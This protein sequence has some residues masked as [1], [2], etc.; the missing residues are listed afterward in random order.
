MLPRAFCTSCGTAYA[1]PADAFCSACGVPRAGGGPSYGPDPASYAPPPAPPA[2]AYGYGAPPAGPPPYGY[3]PP[4]PPYAVPPPYRFVDPVTGRPLADWWKR[5]VAYL[6]DGLILAV[7]T[8]I[9]EITV[10]SIAIPFSVQQG[11]C[12]QSP[13]FQQ[14]TQTFNGGA[15][16]GSFL[17]L[18]AL[19]LALQGLYFVLMVGGRR[20]QTVGMMALGIAVRDAEADTS[21]GYGRA[22]VRYLVIFAL[23][24]FCF[25][26]QVI[27][28]LSPLW[29]ARRQAWHDHAAR[30]V[31]TDLR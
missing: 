6:L 4:P 23:A 20:G 10:F 3:A 25:I 7:P 9:L 30:S 16:I 31:V 26:A 27:D 22:V 17:G 18:A 12:S 2:P 5:F 19:V 11:T 13:P 21:I 24:L 14:C 15:F 28:F 29:D 8:W 1:N